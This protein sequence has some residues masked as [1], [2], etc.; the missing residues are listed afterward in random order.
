VGYAGGS[1]ASPTYRRIGDHT[2]AFQVQYDPELLSYDELL[3]VFW[4]DHDPD[5]GQWSRQYRNV[6][7]THDE[8]QR[9]RAE[10]SRDRIASSR[11][12][13][14]TTA[15]EPLG[16]FTPAEEYHQKYYLRR[17]SDLAKEYL[18]IYPLP[19]D[20][21]RSTAVARVNGFLGGNG[22]LED[23]EEVMPS[24]GLSPQGQ[25]R[26]RGYA[27]NSPRRACPIPQKRPPD[28]DGAAREPSPV[29]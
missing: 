17:Y 29:R 13:E 27:E 6:V 16:T 21:I 25:R 12:I 8:S 4:T 14:V 7:F 18:A 15:V 24:L 9:K 10:A 23:L 3:Q 2:E 20:F 19:E 5:R 11:G 28:L 22:T 1:T 26:L